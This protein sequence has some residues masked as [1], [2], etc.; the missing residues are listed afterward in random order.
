M[1]KTFN[2]SMVFGFCLII[3]LIFK[4]ANPMIFEG[5]TSFHCGDNRFS[6]GSLFSA[7]NVA[8]SGY[9]TKS[10]WTRSLV[11]CNQVCLAEP[12]WCVS[13]NFDTKIDQEKNKNL[14]ELNSHGIRQNEE[15]LANKFQSRRGFIFSQIRPAKYGCSC[16][17]GG[18]CDNDCSSFEV[19]CRCTEGFYGTKCEYIDNCQGITCENGGTCKD[20]VN[21]FTCSCVPGYTGRFCENDI[22]D[23]QGITCENGGTCQDLVN[24]FTCSCVPG[25]EGRL[26]DNDIDDCQGITCGNG[27]TC[28]DLV[29]DFTCSCVAGYTGRFCE[30]DIDDCQ[31]ITCRS[32]G[33]CKDLVNNFTCSCVPGYTGRFC[34]NDINDCQG[35]TCQNGG[36]C[37]DLLNNFTCSCVPGYTAR[38]CEDIDD[39]QGITCKNGGTCQ[40]LVNNFKCSCVP[41]YTG[42]FCEND[43]DDCQGITCK[44]GGT[45][46]DLVNN[47]TCSC[48]PGYTGRFCENDIDDCQ[49]ITCGN[50][51]TCKDLVNDFTCSCVPGYTG[52]FCENDINDCQEITC[53]NG[54]TCKDMLNNFTCSCVPGYTGRF[55]ES[56]TCDI[57]YATYSVNNV[58]LYPW[59]KAAYAM[60]FCTWV[61][62]KDS[63]NQYPA[64]FKYSNRGLGFMYRTDGT[65]L[66]RIDSSSITLNMKIQRDGNWQHL[67]IA[68]RNTDGNVSSYRNGQLVDSRRSF[69]TGGSIV[70]TGTLNICR[71]SDLRAAFIGKIS[72]FNIWSYFMTA[73]QIASMASSCQPLTS[74]GDLVSWSKVKN[75][76]MDGQVS[77]ACPGTCYV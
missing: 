8:L 5:K 13:V 58:I 33:T 22:D 45:C 25:Y 6:I 34:E 50:G 7:E 70:G 53:Q 65:V 3:V 71:R 56:S 73:K 77:K 52:R 60:T 11:H 21:N 41:G 43:I 2:F 4:T 68:W 62:L 28:K 27:G 63:R 24:N 76:R 61:Q 46:K 29:N 1:A 30:N 32:G 69:T 36:T 26:C 15:F 42:R 12:D 17:N 66:L 31:G 18:T 59:T 14:C 23:C 72:N 40:D 39:C 75:T 16:E 74:E 19:K 54:G 35:I 9:V 55:C 47:F 51:G 57:T 38:F 64:S 20:L 44:N 49:G 67:C 48:V 10:V 37:Q